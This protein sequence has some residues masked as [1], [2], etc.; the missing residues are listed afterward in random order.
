MQQNGRFLVDFALTKLTFDNHISLVKPVVFP[1][2][3]FFFELF[4]LST[5]SWKFQSR[6]FYFATHYCREEVKMQFFLYPTI[7]KSGS[8]EPSLKHWQV[9]VCLVVCF[10]TCK[11]EKHS[12][13]AFI[14]F[15]STYLQKK[16]RANKQCLKKKSTFYEHN[17]WRH[18]FI[19]F[20]I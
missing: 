3:E 1:I 12:R 4:F 18:L 7:N 17:L 9:D 16:S 13:S 6:L 11:P 8:R 15:F 14:W 20:I 5:V 10:W 19:Y 2:W